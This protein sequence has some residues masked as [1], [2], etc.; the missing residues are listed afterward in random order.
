MRPPYFWRAGL[1][2]HAREAAPVAR[3][4]LTP[5]AVL[6]SLGVARRIRRT[7]PRAV[8][9]PV[10][11]IGNLTVGGSGK[12]PVVAAVRARL[13]ERGLRAA[14]LSRGYGGRLRTPTRV[15]P[16][17]H[18]AREVGDEPLMLAGTGETWI[19][20][21]RWETACE[22]ASA[23]VDVVVMDDG[24]Q[25]PTLAK[26]LSLLVVDGE[27][28]FGNGHVLPKGPLREPVA[29][30]LSRSDAVI[31]IG[32]APEPEPLQAAGKPLLRARIAPREEAPGGALVAFAGIGRPEKVFDSLAAAGADLRECVAFPDHHPYSQRDLAYLRGL[33]HDHAARLVT[34]QKDLVRLAGSE[35]ADL[36]VWRV[37]ACFEDP[38]ALDALL[39]ACLEG[40]TG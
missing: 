18:T 22:M 37:T 38:A 35:R 24:H 11:C 40:R 33:A 34:T 7:R 29:E 20:A 21:N 4:L 8:R 39:D 30:G 17:V 25:N 23:G 27:A 13:V 36:L 10:I 5:L 19:G 12:T 2:P 28:P 1:D 31:L 6:Y 3:A 9:I 26:D 32:D 16:A 15:D 14:S